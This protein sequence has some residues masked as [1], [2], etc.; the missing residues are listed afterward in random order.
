M[1]VSLEVFLDNN[2]SRL[3]ENAP[4][5]LIDK[6]KLNFKTKTWMIIDKS[7]SLPSFKKSRQNLEKI[8]NTYKILQNLKKNYK[9]FKIF[10]SS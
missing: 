7:P 9:N 2:K 1:R 8:C 10:K 4:L 5:K 3:D 6:F